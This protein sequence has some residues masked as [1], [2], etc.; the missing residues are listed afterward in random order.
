MANDR[1]YRIPEWKAAI[2]RLYRQGWSTREISRKLALPY[3]EV[4]Y[5]VHRMM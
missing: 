3:N 2:E 5:V 1:L 4:L